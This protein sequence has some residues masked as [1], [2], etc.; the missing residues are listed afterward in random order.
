MKNE[1]EDELCVHRLRDTKDCW[2]L[3]QDQKRK[4]EVFSSSVFRERASPAVTLVLDF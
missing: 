1:G 2:Q 4:G 3:S